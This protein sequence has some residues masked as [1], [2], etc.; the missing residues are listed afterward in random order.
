MT[1]FL[2]N[3]KLIFKTLFCIEFRNKK[4]F[5]SSLLLSLVILLIFSFSLDVTSNIDST[6]ATAL[7]W[8]TLAFLGNM[9]VS[10]FTSH[11]FQNNVE[12]MFILS[13]ASSL[14][15]FFGF[16]LSSFIFL[17]GLSIFICFLIAL[18]FNFS[19]VSIPLFGIALALGLLG[20]ACLSTLVSCLL[21]FQKNKDL[22]TLI[23]FLPLAI[24]LLM[25]ATK[26]T[27]QIFSH[28]PPISLGFL[29]GFDI[30][31]ITLSG[32]LFEYGLEVF[33]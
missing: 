30:I 22:L 33:S 6:L 32:L 3:M 15:L 25:T 18:F 8:V 14:S 12:H 26:A 21:R 19:F 27:L 10:G 31:L 17:F 2:G 29:L 23:V 28:V 7:L 24:P 13:G 9:V 11:L 1:H 5:F 20:Y 16:F 4:N